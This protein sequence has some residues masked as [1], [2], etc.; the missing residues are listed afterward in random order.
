M[1]DSQDELPA[2]RLGTKEHWD[3]VYARETREHAVRR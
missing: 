3:M 1:A 2:S